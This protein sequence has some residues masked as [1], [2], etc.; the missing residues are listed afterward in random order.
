MPM[1]DKD[2]ENIQEFF[3]EGSPEMTPEEKWD[4]IF[5]G[6]LNK[7]GQKNLN[8]NLFELKL[9]LESLEAFFSSSYLEKMLFRYIVPN[10]RNYEFYL[11]TFNQIAGRI[12][13]HLKALDFKKDKYSL[14]F[15]EFIVES[16]LESYM[17]KSLP[18]LRDVYMPE[19]WFYSLRIFLQ[20]I[21]TLSSEIKKVDMVPQKSY[22]SLKKLYHKELISNPIIISLLRRRFIPK[23][24][25]IYQPDISN[26]INT[27]R[28]KDL[29]KH[30]GVFFVFAYR[31]LRINNFIDQNLKK[32]RIIDI[33][34]PLVL[35]LKRNLEHL[36]VFYER[37]LENSMKKVIKEKEPMALVKKAFEG[38]KT[39]YQK[40]F[41]GELPN[42][43]QDNEEKFN[44]R[45][46]IKNIVMI[47][48]IAIQEV[49]ETVA[50]VFKPDITGTT[51]FDRYISRKEQSAAVKNK[52]QKLHQKIIDYFAKKG[53]VTQAD[54]LFDLNMFIENDVNYLMFAE[55]NEF[56]TYYNNLIKINF[57]SEI[58]LNLKSF[59][60]FVASLLKEQAET[61]K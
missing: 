27:I 32:V 44:K 53:N 16:I 13:A 29:K 23:M 24:D 25:K 56:L 42:Y 46:I 5:Y 18:Y 14:N 26:V 11:S 59:N 57:S 48:D 21:V 58:D 20:N 3:P 28:N 51:I 22:V 49:I 50:Q 55:W 40:I 61:G 60:T 54:V 30:I 19:S 31:I 12:I 38:L 43:F 47:S 35:V 4:A 39:E 9:W 6:W 41:D 8:L 36:F 7:I 17:V 1:P 52:L 45:K 2:I 15:E 37:F 33:A 10:Q 34:I